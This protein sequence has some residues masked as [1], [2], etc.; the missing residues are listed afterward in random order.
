MKTTVKNLLLTALTVSTVV[1]AV[2]VSLAAAANAD[3]GV[4]AST[5]PFEF[6]NLDSEDDKEFWDKFRESVMK[7]KP[8]QDP[9]QPPKVVDRKPAEPP[10]EAPKPSEAPKP[11]PIERKAIEPTSA[12][13]DSRG[14]RGSIGSIGSNGS[15]GSIGSSS[16]S[17]S[18][19]S[20][21]SNGS[22]GRTT[23]PTRGVPHYPSPPY[24][25][26][27]PPYA[28]TQPPYAPGHRP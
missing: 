15:K 5:L 10:K 2:D 21:G 23:Q 8:E 12:R 25:P 7:D 17:G 4:T 14:S 27:Q 26:T 3:I 9:S 20:S 13:A 24:A 22:N 11:K 19:G 18:K 28:P 16:S 1:F 6:Q